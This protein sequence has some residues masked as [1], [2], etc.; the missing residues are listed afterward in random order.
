MSFVN[1]FKKGNPLKAHTPFLLGKWIVI[2]I[3][4]ILVSNIS[5]HAQKPF[6]QIHDNPDGTQTFDL[7]ISLYRTPNLSDRKLYEEVIENMARAVCEA[8]NAGHYI[9]TIKIFQN[10][11]HQ[12]VTDIIWNHKEGGS[13]NPGGINGRIAKI[14]IGDQTDYFDEK[15]PEKIVTYDWME[16]TEHRTELGYTLAHEFSHYAYS[17][18]DQYTGY[19]E[20][21]HD[22]GEPLLTD[23]Q[24]IPSILNNQRYAWG[25]NWEWLNFD[26]P[27]NYEANNAHGRIWGISG[28]DLL[29][30]PLAEDPNKGIAS[31][32]PFRIVYPSLATRYPTTQYT[33][34]IGSTSKIIRMEIE[35]NDPSINPLRDLKIEWMDNQVE[36]VFILDHSSSMNS[37]NGLIDAKRALKRLVGLVPPG[38]TTVGLTSFATQGVD[39]TDVPMTSIPNPVGSVVSNI[40]TTIDN[41]TILT[42]T[43]LYDGALY[44]LNV[45]EDYRTANNT[46]AAR[47]AML[48][49]DGADNSSIKTSADVENAYKAGKVPLFT[50][51]YGN[52]AHHSVIEGLAKKTSGNFYA[53]ITDP[54]SLKKSYIDAVSVATGMQS[55]PVISTSSDDWRFTVD[56][57]MT[58]VIFEIS[59]EIKDATGKVDFYVIDPLTFYI[60]PAPQILR[61][62]PDAIV[63]PYLETATITISGQ[64]LIN[65]G[66]GEWT[67]EVAKSG[68][69]TVNDPDAI[70]YRENGPALMVDNLSGTTIDYPKPLLL[71]ASVIHD[72]LMTG[73]TISATLEKPDSTSVPVQLYDDGTHGDA[74][75]QDG[76]YSNV[77]SEYDQNGVYTLT[78]VADN[79]L[80]TAF[81]TDYG[82]SYAKG[83]NGLVP[84]AKTL[85]PYTTNF[86]RLK[87]LRFSVNG[88]VSDDHGNDHNNATELIPDNSLIP[89][90]IETPMDKDFFII[91]LPVGQ[92]IIIRISDMSPE[93]KAE[94]IV[95]G[96]DGSTV[97]GYTNINVGSTDNGY[98]MLPVASSASSDTVYVAVSDLDDNRSNVVYNISAG[99]DKHGDQII[100]SKVEV[101]IKDEALHENNIVKPRFYIKN[102]GN[103]PLSDFIVHYYFTADSGE[104]PVLEDYYSPD[105]N[106]TL[107]NITAN[108]YVVSFNYAGVTLDTG[109]V[110]P[111]NSGNVIGIHYQSWRP[112]DKTNDF[113][114]P[115][116]NIFIK[117]DKIAV[118]SSNGHLI[119]GSFPLNY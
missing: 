58:S 108:Q 17:L 16:N 103:G 46:N 67:F 45:L 105:C 1:F 42:G 14:F 9:G 73:L 20:D 88:V 109:E 40:H 104:T 56:P 68:N 55:I 53:Y 100:A 57:S 31:A 12:E 66:P 106:V 101:Y 21:S 113:S 97:L 10:S 99:Q 119:S 65:H 50:F 22:P 107:S 117:S 116:S 59:Y 34:T 19:V 60:N 86:A 6:S 112:M 79:K 37:N 62:T 76:V 70:S 114:N 61:N 23:D 72:K 63:Y 26:T 74:I 25:G 64:A 41:I 13:A 84:V 8:S 47:I 85:V 30:Q 93:M 111:D 91:I 81:L 33:Y 69:I 94:M 51:G 54:G 3:S 102:T 118:F 4:I 36:L 2:A 77:Y 83:P 115:G 82:T 29:I 24:T 11:R 32:Q 71:T 28:W 78:V 75:A 89:G 92:D 7:A 35:L 52:N 87:T 15:D 38:L 98:L 39:I 27:D 96:S 80:G 18:A 90:K 44:G 95:Y 5:L 43:A 110:I 49:S 48:L